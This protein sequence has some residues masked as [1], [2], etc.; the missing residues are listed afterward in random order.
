MPLRTAARGRMRPCRSRGF[1]LVEVLIVTSLVAVLAAVVIAQVTTGSREA[2]LA[3]LEHNEHLLNDVIVA[4]RLDHRG[5]S[6]NVSSGK[7]PQLFAATNAAGTIGT[8]GPSFPHGPY[9]AGTELPSNPRTDSNTVT[10]VPSLPPSAYHGGGW[11][12]HKASGRVIADRKATAA[13]GTDPDAD[14]LV[15]V[16]VK[17]G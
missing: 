4:Y 16:K 11:L 6:P 13:V 12:F 9:L 5:M 1:T 2:Q 7:L 14:E 10:E 3:A 8:P 15:P 17:K